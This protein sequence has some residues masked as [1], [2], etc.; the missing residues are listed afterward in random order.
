MKVIKFPTR[1]MGLGIAVI[2]IVAVALATRFG[3]FNLISSAESK[4]MGLFGSE[5]AA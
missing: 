4:V 2:A 3:L 5:K 1:S